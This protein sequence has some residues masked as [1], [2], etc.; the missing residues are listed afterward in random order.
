MWRDGWRLDSR[1]PFKSPYSPG[2]LVT[3]VE[4]NCMKYM[5][6]DV[7]ELAE[8]SSAFIYFIGALDAWLKIA[9]RN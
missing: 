1:E 5:K 2:L 8:L 3:C 4:V 6:R 9:Q 7:C